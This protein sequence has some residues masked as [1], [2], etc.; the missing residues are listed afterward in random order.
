MTV[1]N[2]S[3]TSR[4]RPRTIASVIN[5]ESHNPVLGVAPRSAIALVYALAAVGGLATVRGCCALLAITWPNAGRAIRHATR[6]GLV[7]VRRLNRRTYVVLTPA[8]R[9]YL[10]ALS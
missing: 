9:T 3:R 5:P 7:S 10:E 1:A 6:C 8:A 4:R 2:A